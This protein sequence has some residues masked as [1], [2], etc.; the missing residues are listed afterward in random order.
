MPHARA[1]MKQAM[2]RRIESGVRVGLLAYRDGEPVAWCSTAPRA[3][4]VHLGG[5]EPAPSRPPRQT[6]NEDPD[7]VWSIT[8]FY[9]R[10]SVRRRGV[11]SL[12]IEEAMRRAREDT[13][14]DLTSIEALPRRNSTERG[15]PLLRLFEELAGQFEGPR[16]LVKKSADAGLRRHVMRR[17]V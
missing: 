16:L 10:S 2:F 11:M 7:S 14:P 5:P 1:D 12:L 9:V 8:C 17:G 15:L 13:V 4:F 6:E 3:T